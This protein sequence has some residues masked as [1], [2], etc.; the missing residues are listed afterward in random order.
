[1]LAFAVPKCRLVANGD[2]PRIGNATTA[3][4]MSDIFPVDLRSDAILK[5]TV[6]DDDVMRQFPARG[7][8]HQS[9]LYVDWSAI[10]ESETVDFDGSVV[11]VQLLP[12]VDNYI[13]CFHFD[14]EPISEEYFTLPIHAKFNCFTVHGAQDSAIEVESIAVIVRNIF[15]TQGKQVELDIETE[16]RR[17]PGCYSD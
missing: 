10:L 12:N 7:S 8:A 17:L 5:Q 3:L 15:S 16:L 6:L 13:R 2:S 9:E 14:T 1:M 11:I 4:Q